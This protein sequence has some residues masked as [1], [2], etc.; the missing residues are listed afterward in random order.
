MALDGSELPAMDYLQSSFLPPFSTSMADSL[1]NQEGS[2]NAD[3]IFNESA[4][5]PLVPNFDGQHTVLDVLGS[6]P[7]GGTPGSSSASG[8]VLE[9][10]RSMNEVRPDVSD[11]TGVPPSSNIEGPVTRHDDEEQ[12]ALSDSVLIPTLALF[13]ERLGGVMPI[14]S[15]T[16]LFSRL[17]RE[18]HHNSPHFAAMLLAMSALTVMQAQPSN[19][20]K[21]AK[22]RRSS[23]RSR[24]AKAIRLLGEA[25][26]LRESPFMGSVSYLWSEGTAC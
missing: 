5:P 22:E 12:H 13:Y 16:W 20:S 17:D 24:R 14:F 3:T 4:M 1:F 10:S 21:E 19:T 2:F 7:S 9:N 11:G 8:S 25:L 6:F 18:D 26:K 15:R 23:G